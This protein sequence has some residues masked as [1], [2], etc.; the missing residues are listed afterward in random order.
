MNKKKA[1]Y[2]ELHPRGKTEYALHMEFPNFNM[3]RFIVKIKKEKFA[4]K[5]FSYKVKQRDYIKEYKM[6][7]QELGDITTA[8]KQKIKQDYDRQIKQIKKGIV[9]TFKQY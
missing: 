6:M 3:K 5:S 9:L 4:Q 1:K 7:L 2:F 8:E